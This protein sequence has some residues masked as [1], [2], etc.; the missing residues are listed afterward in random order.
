M[1]TIGIFVTIKIK[2]IVW[3]VI[4]QLKNNTKAPGSQALLKSDNL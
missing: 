3:E 1:T 4:I 2:L